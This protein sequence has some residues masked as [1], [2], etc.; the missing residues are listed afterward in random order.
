MVK[1]ARKE[2]VIAVE[3]E[4]S[5]LDAFKAAEWAKVEAPATAETTREQLPGPLL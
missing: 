1:V 2:L 5:Q 3:R 4:L